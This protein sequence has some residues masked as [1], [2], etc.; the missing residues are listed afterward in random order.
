M[1]AYWENLEDGVKFLF[2]YLFLAVLANR[3]SFEVIF[4][5]KERERLFVVLATYSS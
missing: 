1:E 2:I 3:G 5:W 4:M